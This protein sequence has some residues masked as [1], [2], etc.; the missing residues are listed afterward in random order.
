MR[1]LV[2]SIPHL[3]RWAVKIRE[4]QQD[5]G[6]FQAIENAV[7]QNPNCL[8]ADVADLVHEDDSRRVSELISYLEK[9]GRLTRKREGR[10][11]RLMHSSSDD[12]P[13]TSTAKAG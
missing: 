2:Y 5:L 3:A 11:Y 1:E 12:S 7:I 4:H 9:A 8:Q 13:D 6:L 10:A